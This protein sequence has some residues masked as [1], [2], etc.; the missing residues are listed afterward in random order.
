MSAAW[1]VALEAFWLDGA[2]AEQALEL[3]KA[4]GV[5]R[6]EPTVREMLGLE[7]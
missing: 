1:P 6:L 5:T 7:E 2:S 3:G 4:S